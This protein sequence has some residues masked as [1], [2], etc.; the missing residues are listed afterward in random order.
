MEP[1]GCVLAHTAWSV[2]DHCRKG[3][4]LV[5]PQ[6]LSGGGFPSSSAGQAV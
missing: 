4:L 6:H 3:L 2:A 1:A 5:L